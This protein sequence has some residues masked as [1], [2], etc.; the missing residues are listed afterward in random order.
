MCLFSLPRLVVRGVGRSRRDEIGHEPSKFGTDIYVVSEHRQDVGQCAQTIGIRRRTAP[1]NDN[2][3]MA[4][5]TRTAYGL[6]IFSGG[7]R[8]DRAG[9]YDGDVGLV[10]GFG[11]FES[12]GV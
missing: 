6:T 3:R 12:E 5:A 1:Y 9:V 8:G 10:P 2:R 11:R 4:S 7:R